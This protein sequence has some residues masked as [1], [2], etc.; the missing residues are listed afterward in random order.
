M[1]K[2]RYNDHIIIYYYILFHIIQQPTNIK[3]E[4]DLKIF[5]TGFCHYLYSYSSENLQNVA[6]NIISCSPDIDVF[7]IYC[8][9]TRLTREISRFMVFAKDDNTTKYSRSKMMQS[10]SFFI[11]A[12]F[13]QIDKKIILLFVK[14]MIKKTKII[15]KYV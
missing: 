12:I 10:Q 5:T 15:Y 4:Y 11:L 13:K 14:D 3:T 6:Y 1:R 9:H 2:T 7:R 8:P